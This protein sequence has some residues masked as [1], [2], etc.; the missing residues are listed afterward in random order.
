MINFNNPFFT[1]FRFPSIKK[2]GSCFSSGNCFTSKASQPGPAQ[3]G[4]AQHGPAQLGSAQ[5]GSAQHGPAQLGPAQLGPAQPGSAQHG[6]AQLGPAQLGPARNGVSRETARLNVGSVI[7]QTKDQIS[8]I[9]E[10]YSSN[11][12]AT[13]NINDQDW[14]TVADSF[15]DPD[16]S[17]KSKQSYLNQLNLNQANALLQKLNEKIQI[18]TTKDQISSIIETYSNNPNATNNINDQ[19]WDTVADS[20]LDHNVSKKSKQSYLTQL[21]LREANA[22]L[23]KLNKKIQSE[24]LNFQ[25][26]HPVLELPAVPKHNVTWSEFFREDITFLEQGQLLL[27]ADNK[28]EIK[29]WFKITS[30]G[31][32]VKHSDDFYT[33]VAYAEAESYYRTITTGLSL[34]TSSDQYTLNTLIRNLKELITKEKLSEIPSEKVVLIINRNIQRLETLKHVIKSKQD[35]KADYKPSLESQINTY[36][37]PLYHYKRANIRLFLPSPPQ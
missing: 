10:T 26:L 14:D 18:K 12:N 20:F 11:P 17:K 1:N 4:P 13:N 2:F 36:L 24:S 16:V 27:D 3:L 8:S 34:T 29:S 5:H 19:D 9:I 21:N 30:M 35:I 32:V 23:Q 7:E 15:L 6:S 31:G 25:I 33:V 28:N 37:N 22:L